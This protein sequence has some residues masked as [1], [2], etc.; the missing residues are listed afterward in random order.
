M[1]ARTA[2]RIRNRSWVSLSAV[3]LAAILG[4]L[5]A[6]LPESGVAVLAVVLGLSVVILAARYPYWVVLFLT[7][8]MPFEN[9]ILKFLPVPDQ[10]YL[11]SQFAGEALL[12][13]TFA[14]LILRKLLMGTPFRRTPVDVPLIAFVG[15]AILSIAVNQAPMLGSVMNIRVVLRYTTLFYLL[16]NLDMTPVQVKQI[17]RIILFVGLVQIIIGGLQL[18]GG[19]GLNSFLTPKQVDLE[20][21]GQSRQFVLVNRGREIGSAFGTLGDTIFFSL[22]MLIVLVIYLGDV[23]RLNAFRLFI[24]G[25]ILL[26]IGFSYARAVVFGTFPVLLVFYR[27]RYGLKRTLPLLLL[28][29]VAVIVA[30]FL[31]TSSFN[32]SEF[33]APVKEKQNIIQNVSGIFSR[34][35]FTIA[36]KQRTGA[37]IGIAPT[38]LASRPI[39]G[40]GPD[41]HT[42]IERL[43]SS[44]PSFLL[45]TLTTK[46]FEDVYWVAVLAYYGVVG[47]CVLLFL[48]Q[49][50]FASIWKIYKEASEALTRNLAFATLCLVGLTPYFLFFYR[51]LEFRIYSFYFWMLTAL[52]YSLF[53]SERQSVMRLV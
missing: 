19:S 38:I 36:Q 37:L 22:F 12:Y 8:F 21:A 42:T 40:Y 52:V 34:E 31:I 53:R 16:V 41:E 2:S 46:G 13:I 3:A 28:I 20:I 9:F 25:S 48:F 11:A 24:L 18:V 43:N 33:V 6:F 47:V 32:T 10:I 27:V 23:Q 15:V 44:Q 51:V 50:L 5:A 14:A 4:G 1:K 35:Y 30:L 39:L 7:A 17:L 26:A 49:R 45:K 29:F